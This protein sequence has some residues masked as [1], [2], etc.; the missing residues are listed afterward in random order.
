MTPTLHRSI[1]LLLCVL[2]ASVVQTHAQEATPD[3]LK[4][5]DRNGDGKVSREEMPKIFDLID[6]DK[7]GIGT[8]A[9]LTAYFTKAKGKGQT[10]GA[11]PS[12][13][14]STA[15]A[16]GS[17][18]PNEPAARGALPD[19]VEKRAIT[20]WSDGTRMAG[21]LYL[22]KN[23][24]EGEKLPA[25]VF[26][27]G[28]GGTKGGTGGRLG[29]IFAEK[30]YVAL[31]FDYRGWGESESQLMAAEP[32]PKP[33]EK[34]E[35]TIKVKALR[36]QM[37]YTDQ[38]EDI[39]AAISFL[40]GEPTVDAQRIGIMGSSYGGGLV[41]YMAGTDPRVKCVVAQVPG[42]GGANRD[43]ALAAAYK[44]HTQQARGEVEPVPLE[45]GKMTGKMEKYSNMRTNA[46][47]SIGFSGLE[48]AAKIAVPALFVVAEN[49]ELS[50]NEIVAEAQKQIAARGVPSKYH[51]VKGITHYGIY[52]E[53]FQEATTLEIAWFEEH[54]KGA[55]AKPAASTP[56]TPP[57]PKT[58]PAANTTPKLEEGF[59]ALDEDK[60]GKLSA[61]EFAALKVGTT[62]FREHP[63]QLEPAF[64]KLDADADGALTLEE[65]RNIARP[66][67]SKGGQGKGKAKRPP[68]ET[69]APKASAEATSEKSMKFA[70]A[71]LAFFEK[72]IRPVLIKSC[73]ECHSAEADKLK[74]GLALDARVALLK[75][76]DSGAAVVLG[77]PEESLLIKS[78][79][80]DDPDLKMP[81]EKHGG[82]LSEAVIANFVEWVKRGA[83][84]P[85][86]QAVA[87]AQK[88]E[89]RMDHWAFKPVMDSPAPA[90]K[91]TS[92][93]RTEVDRFVLAELEKKGLAPVA[94]AEPAALL[95]RVH[96]DLTG[97]PPTAEQVTA[98]LAAPSESRIE[99]VI[100]EL[101]KSPQFGERWG[102][103]WLDVARYAESSGKE[104]DFA[105]PHAWRYR[106]Y[107]IKA[108][109]ADMPFDQFIREQIAGDLFEARDDKERA[110]L[111]IATGFLAIGP[112]SHIEKNPL[113][114]EMDV[115]DEQID[116]VSQAF[117]GL[118]MACARCHDHKYDPVSQRDYY[119]LAGIF[120]STDTKF[121]TVKLIQNNNPGT[122]VPLPPEANQPN[123][124][125]PLASRE[126]DRLEKN[127]ARDS[128]RLAELTKEK[129]FASSE[130]VRTRIRLATD[131]AHLAAY[132]ADG[133]PKQFV[134]CVLEREKPRDSALLIRGEVQKPGNMVQRGLPMLAKTSA[135]I[136]SGS[137][138][139]E[140]AS[141]IS[142]PDNP[143]TARVIVNR[144]WLH[145]FGQGIVTT[146]D[147][148]GLS[149]QA[150]SH[151]ALL[152]HL[153][154]R[155]VK[156]G[157]SVKKLIREL[158]TSRVYALSTAHD[159]KNF[160]ADPDN[161]L[162]WRM[163][164]RRLDAE[165]IRDA[166]LLTAGK[167]D[168]RPP[169][170]SPVGAYGEGYAVG[171]NTKL[172]D[173]VSPHR[174]VYLPVVRN[175]P[176][177]SLTLFDMTPGSIVTGQRPQTTVPAQSLY[178]LNSP[179]VLKAAEFAAQRLLT[180]R[181]KSE[182]HRVKLAYERIFN[183]PPTDSEVEAALKFVKTKPDAAQGWAALC[184]SLWASHEFLARS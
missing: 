9:E 61:E 108:F 163:T 77:K 130:F 2:C 86:G 160:E 67:Q 111:L 179:Y 35:L 58:A 82:K 83:P 118:T 79:R 10:K 47:K 153:A 126:R 168:L 33:D 95:R 26:C 68:A 110:E 138:R 131:K 154:T 46:A 143:L 19:T 25:I 177:E 140:L 121:G 24:K 51:V 158:M 39:R 52:R 169:T 162:L 148:F 176:L 17:A 92:W 6:A 123:G 94:D 40:A 60:T 171:A 54:L 120:R 174:S 15:P 65:Y 117:L 134:T 30:G 34:G 50:N 119:A 59:K 12:P 32:Q 183:R 122:L 69:E 21:D 137:G 49:E 144:V 178:L 159:A 78:L 31:A 76:G 41:T 172:I 125:K 74:A 115:V 42:L 88:M 151:P 62:Y 13:S 113:Q 3:W 104:T 150:P 36:W 55:A 145:L 166:M 155:F 71:D 4:K 101:M 175:L 38:T 100:D 5:I 72:N 28:T 23:R 70:D 181:P 167:L 106:D 142:S 89:A 129:M 27:A 16:P 135:T 37:N 147:N 97:L 63:E 53:G 139:K 124:L 170:G 114:F 80:H 93:P 91:S 29:P 184:Q 87:V 56:E 164:P 182:P 18:N 161:T 149:G 73:Y 141:W 107:V 127:V 128:A 7:D 105:Y 45:T 43:R 99:G 90:V 173:Q 66:R 22:P 157:W 112:K 57:A 156:E 44:L 48:A 152:D 109:N 20:I 11:T 165:S 1:P 102:R 75:G 64:K 98:F 103:H 96:L 85:E 116:T 81:P 133:T 8:V 14:P 180:D 146:P 132:E 136:P 84:M